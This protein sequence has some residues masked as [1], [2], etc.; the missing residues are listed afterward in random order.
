[1]CF[2]VAPADDDS[3]S[4]NAVTDSETMVTQSDGMSSDV[5]P[6]NIHSELR[7][8]VV[9]IN[10]C[11]HRIAIL[12]TAVHGKRHWVE[13]AGSFKDYVETHLGISV[14]TVQ[15]LMK[16]LRVCQTHK[17]PHEK[18]AEV[19]W[20]KIAVVAKQITEANRDQVLADLKDFSY[21]Q[22]REKY[23]Q[24]SSPRASK[25]DAE[26]KVDSKA[27]DAQKLLITPPL[28]RAIELVKELT[29]L[30]DPQLI[31]EFMAEQFLALSMGKFVLNRIASMN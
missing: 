19:G 16:V 6:Q 11:N 25:K 2:D 5:T 15:E 1:M 21:S 29:D 24:A 4:L 8:L 31:F 13:F 14:R 20:S 10:E 26:G 30:D 17:I 18:I 23:K 27:K 3:E 28:S 9:R 22:L 12:I 7:T